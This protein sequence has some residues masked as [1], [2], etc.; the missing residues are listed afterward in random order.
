MK[1]ELVRMESLGVIEKITE[2]TDWVH[3][4]VVAEK[5]D[6]S[7]RVCRDSKHLNKAIKCK[8]FHIPTVLEQL[9]AKLAGARVFTKLG[10]SSS[11]WQI[12]LVLIG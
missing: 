10:M 6:R 2:P 8:H 5:P 3:P 9:T 1:H 12:S 11:F 7:L 4:L